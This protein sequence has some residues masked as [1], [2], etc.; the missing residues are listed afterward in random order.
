[1]DIGYSFM[2]SELTAAFL[3]AQLEKLRPIQE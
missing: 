3:Y 1:V 2:P